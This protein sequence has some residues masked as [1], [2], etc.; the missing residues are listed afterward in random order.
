MLRCYARQRNESEIARVFRRYL[1][2][3]ATPPD[4]GDAVVRW[5]R[6]RSGAHNEAVDITTQYL[7]SS[8]NHAPHRHDAP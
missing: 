1:R 4:Q 7:P 3:L 6:L 2:A 5:M 8:E